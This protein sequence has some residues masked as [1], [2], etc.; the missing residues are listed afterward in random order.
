MTSKKKPHFNPTHAEAEA[1][2]EAAAEIE[3]DEISP[4]TPGD[5][6]PESETVQTPGEDLQSRLSAAEAQAKEYLDGWQRA[7]A[8][9]MNYRKR[10]EREQ[11]QQRLYALGSAVKR[12]LPV[13]D[14]LE[15]AIQ[16]VPSDCQGIPWV[17]GINLIYQK[18]SSALEADGVKTVGAVGEPFDPNLHEAIG[19]APSNDHPSGHIIEVL[20]K[21]YLMGDKILR[22][23]MVRVAE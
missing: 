13:V 14:D 10:I 22:P 9:F 15:R 8:E 19:Q 20:Q 7:Q 18:M 3:G 2:Y 23:A 5:T 4:P 1:A 21:G 16:N 11:E 12:Y 17:E 6:H